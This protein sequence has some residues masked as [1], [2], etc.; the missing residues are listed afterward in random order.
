MLF[1]YYLS[2]P[3]S[4]VCHSKN[5]GG[6]LRVDLSLEFGLDTEYHNNNHRRRSSVQEVILTLGNEIQRV[7]DLV[8]TGAKKV[9]TFSL[10]L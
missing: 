8:V 1:T 9:F 6:G 10:I 7:P 2:F 3:T 5:E 4:N